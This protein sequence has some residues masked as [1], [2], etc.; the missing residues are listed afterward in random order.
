MLG[1]F[2]IMAPCFAAQGFMAV[3]VEFKL[4]VLGKNGRVVGKKWQIA[5]PTQLQVKTITIWLVMI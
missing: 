5:P 2:L 1:F 3:G 4:Y